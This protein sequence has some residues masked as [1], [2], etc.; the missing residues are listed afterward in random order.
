MYLD[1]EPL[2]IGV[3]ALR[4]S[5]PSPMMHTEIGLGSD[6]YTRHPLASPLDRS[7]HRALWGHLF[8]R[9]PWHAVGR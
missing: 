6:E 4:L 9:D 7:V 5:D 3:G 2:Q 8:E 1:R